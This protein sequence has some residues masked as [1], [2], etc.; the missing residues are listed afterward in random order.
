MYE[1]ESQ[2]Y[3][4]ELIVDEAKRLVGINSRNHPKDNEDHSL[5]CSSETGFDC[6]GFVK[7]VFKKSGVN[8]SEE[9]RHV[10]EFFDSFGVLSHIPH[11]GDLVFFSRTGKSPTHV[12]IMINDKQYIHAPGKNGTKVEINNL[13]DD[14]KEIP[15]LDENQLYIKNPIG[16]KRPVV[17]NNGRWKSLL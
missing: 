15:L 7:Y 2:N 16:F 9:I 12:G 11:K 4:Q 17:S 3:L 6:S 14:N 1:K 8:V 10:S 13:D 5:G